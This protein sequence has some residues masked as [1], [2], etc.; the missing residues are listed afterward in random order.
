MYDPIHL[1]IWV[2]VLVIVVVLVVYVVT[3]LLFIAGGIQLVTHDSASAQALIP[4]QLLLAQ[5]Q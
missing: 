2:V 1:L 3:H 4:L 5:H